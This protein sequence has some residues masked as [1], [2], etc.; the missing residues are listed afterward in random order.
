MLDVL[1]QA[2][3]Q[4]VARLQHGHVPRRL[5]ASRRRRHRERLGTQAVAQRAGHAVL[6]HLKQR[7]QK[8]D[9]GV[10]QPLRA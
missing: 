1:A 7:L 9:A 4:V 5:A 8:L 10:R 2:E 6:E 3:S